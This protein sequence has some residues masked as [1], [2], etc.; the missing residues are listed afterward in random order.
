LRKHTPP[1]QSEDKLEMSD[2]ARRLL[3]VNGLSIWRTSFLPRRLW[4]LT[5]DVRGWPQASPL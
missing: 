3:F 1:N 2:D 5:F 4:C